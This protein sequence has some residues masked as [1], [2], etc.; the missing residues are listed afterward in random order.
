[1]TSSSLSL[2][3]LTR[4]LNRGGHLIQRASGR[5]LVRLDPEVLCEE[6]CRR[7]G[8]YDF[9]DDGVFREALGRVVRS[10]RLESGLS[11]VGRIAA[12]QDLLRLLANRLRLV[13]D[14][15]RFPEIAAEAVRRP[16]FVTGL[17]RTGTTL[18]HGLL[19]QDPAN[20]APLHWEMI[21][22]SPPPERARY[23]T[24]RRIAAAERQLRWF[25][26]LQ[27][28]LQPIHAVG[29]RMP[30]ECLIITS[31]SLLSLQFQTT[32]YVPSYQTWL[33]T[34]DLRP[35]YEWHR[36]FLQ[37]LQW[38]CPGD[39]WV[40]KA[41]AHLFGL[42]ALFQV[43]PDAGVIFT[44][45]D[46][47]KVAASLASLTTTLRSTFAT[48]VDPVAIGREMTDRWARAIYRALRDRDAGCASPRQFFDVQYADLERDPI[49]VVR[50]IYRHYN[51]PLTPE[52]EERMRAF[53]VENPKDKHGRHRYSLADFGL[54]PD[55][56]RARYAAYMRRFDL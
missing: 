38:R 1:V 4:A 35:C 15:Q 39:R 42:P 26:R 29:A 5:Q 10:M 19:A 40:L 16:L 54:D 6:A 14:R 11:L 17:P 22:P 51:L 49:G 23:T 34:I 25:Q 56:E 8:L 50:A 2:V 33:E 24:D 31:H 7:T 53:L 28:N 37:H 3:S 30:E 45:R 21:F 46:P 27:P 52:A 9:D 41:P 20:R 44:H 13:A 48:T 32:H 12:R 18:L 47:L 43:Y 36:R 55:E